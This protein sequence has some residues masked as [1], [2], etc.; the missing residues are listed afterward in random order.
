MKRTTRALKSAFKA[1]RKNW[2]LW[3]V[4]FVILLLLTL[5]RAFH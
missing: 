2:G 5:W 3:G 1:E 4:L